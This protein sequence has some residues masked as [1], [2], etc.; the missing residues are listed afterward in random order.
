MII[1]CLA[2]VLGGVG[3]FTIQRNAAMT[4]A[5]RKESAGMVAETMLR[6]ADS[7]GPL[8]GEEAPPD[9]PHRSDGGH[10]G[11]TY[12]GSRRGRPCSRPLSFISRRCL[13]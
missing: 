12:L 2:V 13:S 6:V 8:V 11:F 5:A 4:T 1:A 9:S 7:L 3:A 10:A